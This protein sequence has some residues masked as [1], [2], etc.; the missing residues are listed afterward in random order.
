MLDAR[1]VLTIVARRADAGHHRAVCRKDVSRQVDRLEVVD[2]E[3]LT[4]HYY[5][6]SD[7]RMEAYFRD[8]ADSAERAAGVG[9]LLLCVNAGL[10]RLT[11]LE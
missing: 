9:T 8:V 10:F 7:K 5:K 2:G 1:A 11:A 3:L 6:L 4:M